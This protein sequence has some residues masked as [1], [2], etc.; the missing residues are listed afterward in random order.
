[1]S[2][3][4]RSQPLSSESKS[5][6]RL[7]SANQSTRAK[8]RSFSECMLSCAQI[9]LDTAD[10]VTDGDVSPSMV[11]DAAVNQSQSL[12]VDSSER[13]IGGSQ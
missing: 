6:P 4:I 9:V 10:M 8:W 2:S 5:E 3:A 13:W 1:M 7:A 12:K 11:I